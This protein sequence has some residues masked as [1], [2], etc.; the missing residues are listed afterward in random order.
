[1]RQLKDTCPRCN[2]TL[3]TLRYRV[4]RLRGNWFDPDS[5]L[6]HE[7]DETPGKFI[8]SNIIRDQIGLVSISH[9]MWDEDEGKS[10]VDD[11]DNGG[12]GGGNDDEYGDKIVKWYCVNCTMPNFDNIH[13]HGCEEHR[14]SGI[15]RAG[16]FACPNFADTGV[17]DYELDKIQ[18]F[19]ASFTHNDDS[20]PTLI[21]FHACSPHSEVFMKSQPHK[22]RPD[23]LRVIAASLK[24]SGIFPGKCKPVRAK[25]IRKENLHVVH[26]P[27]HVE[28][29][30]VTSC[31]L[32]SYFEPDTYANQY[33]AFY[34]RIAAGLCFDLASL[35]FLGRGKNGF[36]LVRPPGHHAGLHST[37]GSCLYNNAAIAAIAAK[38]AGAKKVL[39]VDWDIHHGNGTQEIFA[40]HNSVLY[41][42]LHRHEGGSFYPGTGGACEVGKKYAKG[43]TVNIP[44]KCRDVGDNDYIFAFQTV[45]LAI[46]SQFDPDLTI[47]SVGFDAP[48][49]CDVS[50]AGYAQMTA[51]LHFLVGKCL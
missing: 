7:E 25:H 3:P 10:D 41:I 15:L 50:L 21:G 14:E 30:N 8:E 34:A 38:G 20:L 32:A 11:D 5:D 48:S 37:M 19:K 35:I 9:W 4:G 13:C 18:K 36:A 49:D 24:T 26:G 17:S 27:L 43:F 40:N 46:V 39:I 22:E 33:S 12:G 51:M 16:L 44:W 1:M 29:M 42:S 2:S 28:Y 47:V 45:V 23:R 31:L 6:D